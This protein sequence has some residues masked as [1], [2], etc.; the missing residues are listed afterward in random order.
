MVISMVPFN[1]VSHPP[2]V[3]QR[4]VS[5][6]TS[7]WRMRRYAFKAYIE[8]RMVVLVVVQYLSH[9]KLAQTCSA[10]AEENLVFVHN[11][12]E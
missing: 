11:R 1:L 4:L 12:R 10:T 9:V 3:L 7:A 2:C 6:E 5:E 8:V